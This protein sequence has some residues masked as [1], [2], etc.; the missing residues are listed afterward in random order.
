MAK[1]AQELYQEREQRF[2]DAVA[3]RKP[4]RVP[5][6]LFAEFFMTKYQGL[7]N[8][9]ALYDYEKMAEAWKATMADFDWDMAPTPL[10]MFP[11]RAMDLLGIK[12]YKWPGQDLADDLPY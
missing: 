2:N 6:V 1:S 7:T 5:I 10:A 9:E 11:G 8:K 12:Q 3:L 4:D